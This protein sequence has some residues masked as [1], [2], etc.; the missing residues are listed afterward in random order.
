[1]IKTSSPQSE[2]Y[3]VKAHPLRLVDCYRVRKAEGNLLKRPNNLL[4]HHRRTSLR[5]ILVSIDAFLPRMRSERHR[6]PAVDAHINHTI[7][8]FAKA[9]HRS[10]ITVSTFQNALV[11]LIADYHHTRANGEIETW[12]CGEI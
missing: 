2:K 1:M 12:L 7:V 8:S 4:F 9:H 10:C 11:A 5:I 6:F 3:A